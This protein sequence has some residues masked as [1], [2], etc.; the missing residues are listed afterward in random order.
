MLM[1]LSRRHGCGRDE[2]IRMIED[3]AETAGPLA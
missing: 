2:L 1:P 3:I